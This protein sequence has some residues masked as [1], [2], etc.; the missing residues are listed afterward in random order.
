MSGLSAATKELMLR[1]DSWTVLTEASEVLGFEF[2]LVSALVLPL[3]D[4]LLRFNLMPY[5]IP[6]QHVGSHLGVG[7]RDRASIDLTLEMSSVAGYMLLS[8]LVGGTA[9]PRGFESA[10]VSVNLIA[11]TMSLA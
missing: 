9:D 6:R 3:H 8:D 4:A 11:D 2:A 1:I 10:P 5:G 7:V